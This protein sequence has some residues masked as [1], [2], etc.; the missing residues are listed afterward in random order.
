MRAKSSV[1]YIL[2]KVKRI[3]SAIS[4][5]WSSILT[6]IAL[7]QERLCRGDLLNRF[8]QEIPELASEFEMLL[9]RPKFKLVEC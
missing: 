9:Q 7:D 5:P 4:D 1:L 2:T 6:G 8:F 3:C